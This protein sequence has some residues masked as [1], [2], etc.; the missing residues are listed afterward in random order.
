[1]LLPLW[2]SPL[3]LFLACSLVEGLANFD[4]IRLKKAVA[5]LLNIDPTSMLFF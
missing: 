4:Q 5:E 2:R 3:L 1:M